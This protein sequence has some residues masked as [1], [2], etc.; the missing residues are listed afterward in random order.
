M[1]AG[2]IKSGGG[3]SYSV[4]TQPPTKIRLKLNRLGIDSEILEKDGVLRIWDWYTAT[5]GQKSKE[6]LAISSLKVSDLSIWYSHE[7]L[8]GPPL[9]DKLLIIDDGSV[10]VR[11]NDEKNWVEFS[12]TRIYP[13]AKMRDCIIIASL[14]RGLHSDWVYK[15]SEV[16]AD[17]VIDFKL[18]ESVD[19]A[20]N[21][22]RIRSMKDIGF[23][24]R[25]HRLKI[26]ENF[27]ITLEK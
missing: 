9:P 26:G 25:W 19:P 2:W 18:D 3:V 13:M 5:L 1:A 8:Q 11:F 27:E 6:K 7:Q 10:G 23:D 20:Q 4:S 12:M 14:V 21:L 22:I 15:R 16:A 17:G 24:G